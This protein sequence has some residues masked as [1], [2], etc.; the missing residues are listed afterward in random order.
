MSCASESESAL[1]RRHFEKVRSHFV[2][3]FHTQEYPF[4]VLVD[5]NCIQLL[6][7]SRYVDVSQGSFIP[8]Q[9]IG[10]ISRNFAAI[11]APLIDD[12]HLTLSCYAHLVYGDT[13]HSRVGYDIDV[14]VL[15]SNSTEFN[16]LLFLKFSELNL[17]P[18]KMII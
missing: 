12:H 5:V 16:E 6:A 14:V 4:Y 1:L 13:N 2:Y 17:N 3:L 10:H 11:L 18:I 7:P 9:H 15:S 8:G